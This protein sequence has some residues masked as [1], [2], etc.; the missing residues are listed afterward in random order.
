[1]VSTK[2]SKRWWLENGLKIAAILIAVV[3]LFTGIDA[4]THSGKPAGGWAETVSFGVALYLPFIAFG[5]LLYLTILWYLPRQWSPR[6]HR[7][8][9]I[10][11]SPVCVSFFVAVFSY[12]RDEWLFPMAAVIALLAALVVRPRTTTE[13]ARYAAGSP[14]EREAVRPVP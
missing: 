8:A 1:M 2:D 11:L 9:A 12:G 4:L 3:T 5:A 14:E 7:A 10:L 13:T 6:L